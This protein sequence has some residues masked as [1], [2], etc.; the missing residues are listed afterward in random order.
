MSE[1]KL[2]SRLCFFSLIV[3]PTQ[4]GVTTF[5][6]KSFVQLLLSFFLP[7]T[8][9]IF[10]PIPEWLESLRDRRPRLNLAQATS[11]KLLSKKAFLS[12]RTHFPNKVRFQIEVPLNLFKLIHSQLLDRSLLPAL[13]RTVGW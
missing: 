13:V 10:A 6:Q 9:S 4:E 11:G 7:S 3:L 12:L 1:I 8:L 2:I 5:E